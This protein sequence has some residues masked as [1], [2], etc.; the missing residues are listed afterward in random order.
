MKKNKPLILCFSAFL[1]LIAAYPALAAKSKLEV[2]MKKHPIKF[3]S[4]VIGIPFGLAGIL[5]GL[6]YL[7]NEDARRQFGQQRELKRKRAA[8]DARLAQIPV[9][10]IKAASL[11]RAKLIYRDSDDKTIEYTLPIDKETTIGRAATNDI[12]LAT[13]SVSRIHAKIRPQREGYVVYDLL[14]RHGT[15]INTIEKEMY[16]LRSGDTINIKHNIL[17]FKLTAEIETRNI[18]DVLR[19]KTKE[20]K[21]KEIKEREEATEE[22]KKV[23]V[24]DYVVYSGDDE[25]EKEN[26]LDENG[27]G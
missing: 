18:S 11:P 10:K 7:T 19:E 20:I 22:K 12:I 9:G 15:Y 13:E 5:L 27:K 25:K 4:F 8:R 23:D 24:F 14:S 6:N 2:Y 21:E 26:P 1:I 17:I 3:Y 16:L